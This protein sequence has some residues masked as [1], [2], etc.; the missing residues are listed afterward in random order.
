MG[1]VFLE[2]LSDPLFSLSFESSLLPAGRN[3]RDDRLAVDEIVGAAAAGGTGRVRR[4]GGTRV[5][6]ALLMG[7]SD[8]LGTLDRV[9]S[10]VDIG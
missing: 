3:S 9:L 4:D 8:D 1:E 6:S 5:P 10:R 7:G 2:P